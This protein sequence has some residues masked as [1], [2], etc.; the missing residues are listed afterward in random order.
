MFR[1]MAER[2]WKE[3]LKARPSVDLHIPEKVLLDCVELV[4]NGDVLE[5]VQR[6]PGENE[7]SF[8]LRFYDYAK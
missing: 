8:R 7:V 2:L 6:L 1:Q 5:E 4:L 3:Y